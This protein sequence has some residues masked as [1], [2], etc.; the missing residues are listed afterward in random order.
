MA[1]TIDGSEPAADIAVL[2][3]APRI[4]A[5]D[6]FQAA[7]ALLMDGH[8]PTIDR[9]RMKLGRGSPNTIN[10]HLDAWWSKLG[11]RLRDLPGQVLPG[12]PESV[13]NSLLQLW[14]LA[15]R[16]S[17]S[18]LL[19]SLEAREA[20]LATATTE[21]QQ[22]AQALTER[23]SA[24]QET[25]A[26]LERALAAS[27][28]QLEEANQRARALETTL[29][30]RG[31]ERT[32][33]HSALLKIE[34]EVAR[35]HKALENERR[36]RAVERTR[37]D[38]RYD[39]QQVRWSEEVDRLRQSLREA[40]KTTKGLMLRLDRALS[41]RDQARALAARATTDLQKAIRQRKEVAPRRQTAKT[42]TPKARTAV[43]ARQGRVE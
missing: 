13:T 21:V 26:A 15:T 32:D 4:T 31:I 30:Q 25:R 11:A 8:R 22:R 5:E 20:A 1:L 29:H 7:D 24:F 27:Q 39:G 19:A 14:T 9:V 41:E 10:E 17:H 38:Q 18:A 37:L 12:L 33:Q 42:T 35:A 6:V 23:D 28:A 16:E 40:H 3:R 2:R 34:G 43:L 36:E